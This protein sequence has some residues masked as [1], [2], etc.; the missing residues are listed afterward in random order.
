VSLLV[1]FIAFDL[2]MGI[3]FSLCVYH[4]YN[5]HGAYRLIELVLTVPY[6][7]FLEQMIIGMYHQ[8]EYGA[9]FLFMIGDAPLVIGI[10]WSVI[11][12]SAMEL[13]DRL[14]INLW[15]RP[16]FDVLLALNI[17]VVMDAIAIRA[18][19]WNWGIPFTDEWFGVRYGNFFGWISVVL[20]FSFWIRIMRKIKNTTSFSRLTPLIPLFAMGLS[21]LCLP[22]VGE[23]IRQSLLVLS[24][25]MEARFET[26]QLITLIVTCSFFSLCVLLNVFQQ[27]KRGFS[28]DYVD[29]IPA[30]IPITFH[31]FFIVLNLIIVDIQET[32]LLLISVIMLVSAVLTHVSPW[33]FHQNSFSRKRKK[34]VMFSK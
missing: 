19:Y 5:H 33:F 21:L 10:G 14:R 29:L 9:G 22:I 31:V 16:F 25:E 28:G 1:H 32:T 11:I 30:S 3:L 6:G 13:S 18:G 2:L 24:L 7:I 4:A 17:D 23:L 20:L 26:V 8:Y 15:L 27:Q 12:Y 34:K